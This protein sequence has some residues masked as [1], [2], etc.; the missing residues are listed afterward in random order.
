MTNSTKETVGTA[1]VAH[2]DGA[3]WGK[4]AVNARLIFA[5]VV[6]CAASF[7]FGYDDKLISPVAALPAFVSRDLAVDL[8]GWR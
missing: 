5:C 7:V 1:Q 6:F 2:I 3:S 8:L 4:S